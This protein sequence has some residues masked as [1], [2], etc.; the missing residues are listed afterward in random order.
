MNIKV[1][2]HFADVDKMV[3]VGLNSK[4]ITKDYRLT[5]Y[6]CYLI[7]Q[8]ADSKKGNCTC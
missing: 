4:R 7:A 8:S 5:R 2:D 3:E 6:A 1:D